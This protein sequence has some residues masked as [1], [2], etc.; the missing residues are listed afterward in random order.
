[1]V[2]MARRRFFSFSATISA[3]CTTKL[4]MA[5]AKMK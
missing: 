1:M 4:N 5:A 3:T 2:R